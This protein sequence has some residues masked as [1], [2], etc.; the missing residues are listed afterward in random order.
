MGWKVRGLAPRDN[1]LA[2][3]MRG[4]DAATAR[5]LAGVERLCSIGAESSDA[6]G[7]LRDFCSWYRIAAVHERDRLARAVRVVRSGPRRVR[8]IDAVAAVVAYDAGYCAQFPRLGEEVFDLQ[9]YAYNTPEMPH[10][11]A[12]DTYMGFVPFPTRFLRPK[13]FVANSSRKLLLSEFGDSPAVRTTE[14][15]SAVYHAIAEEALRRQRD[16]LFVP[17]DDF[18]V[19]AALADYAAA[20]G[21]FTARPEPGNWYGSAGDAADDIL[22]RELGVCCDAVVDTGLPGNARV[23]F[24]EW[25]PVL[26]DRAGEVFAVYRAAA[27]G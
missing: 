19:D 2:E 15:F 4:T 5:A 13:D 6:T 16:K 11:Y 18:M 8:L 7:W 26:L 23:L 17:G 10:T 21:D 9:L 12:Y 1:P 25:A 27:Q 3:F 20:G 14:V 22:D 24:G